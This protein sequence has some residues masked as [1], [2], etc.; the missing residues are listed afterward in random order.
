MG[1]ALK[2]L[3]KWPPL[4][5]EVDKV[6]LFGMTI[7]S[8]LPTCV[9]PDRVFPLFD[10]ESILLARSIVTAPGAR[11]LD[12]GTGSGVLAL[13]AARWGAEVVSTDINPLA[14]ACV[15]H[16]AAVNALTGKVQ[17]RQC[18]LFAGMPT[19]SFDLIVANPPF[20]PLPS[21]LS[22]FTSSDAGPLGLR[23]VGPLIRSARRF[24]KPGGRLL[25]LTMNFA[26]REGAAAAR[27]AHEAFNHV[28]DGVQVCDLYGGGLP[29]EEFCACFSA[30]GP[31]T[32]WLEDLKR[33]GFDRLSYLLLEAR[34]EGRLSHPISP[35]A[36]RETKFSGS[37][38]ARLS[39]Y[40]AWI[41]RRRL[42]SGW[43]PP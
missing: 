6:N 24:L 41:E 25:L 14:L 5:R 13:A 35:P 20:L 40:R 34:R 26:G 10:D 38:Q 4:D 17:W 16:N 2:A 11:V 8:D 37:W 31:T 12:L 9:E 22:L 43:C 27:I 21:G 19:D 33:H 7:E 42:Q 28:T 15:A 29:V 1:P 3:P 32:D 36:L 39:R 30:L 18:D 23:V